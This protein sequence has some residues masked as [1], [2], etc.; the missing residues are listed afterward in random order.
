MALSCSG[1]CFQESSDGICLCLESFSYSLSI[2]YFV[3]FYFFPLHLHSLLKTP[4]SRHYFPG[5]F[6]VVHEGFIHS[7]FYLFG[8]SLLTPSGFILLIFIVDLVQLSLHNH[9]HALMRYPTRDFLCFLH[10]TLFLLSH[11]GL[12]LI[13]DKSVK[14]STLSSKN[15]QQ[16]IREMS[17]NFILDL[18][19]RQK[20]GD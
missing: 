2:S 11:T 16:L 7:L 8:I 19:C 18:S 4:G 6:R 9:N 14:K 10:L 13:H 5:S 1:F 12:K 20:K 15:D 17:E 3:C